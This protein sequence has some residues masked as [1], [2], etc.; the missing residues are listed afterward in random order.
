MKDESKCPRFRKSI[1]CEEVVERGRGK[2]I[3]REGMMETTS[4]RGRW[5]VYEYDPFM[6]GH[7]VSSSN[8]SLPDDFVILSHTKGYCRYT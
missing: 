7:F 3:G 2:Y 5:I 8:S 1:N 4:L 6:S